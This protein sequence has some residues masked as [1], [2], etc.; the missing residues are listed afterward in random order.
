MN[1]EQMKQDIEEASGTCDAKVVKHRQVLLRLATFN[2]YLYSH[3]TK[4]IL[5]CINGEKTFYT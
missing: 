3:R 5:G 1:P 2:R 4:E